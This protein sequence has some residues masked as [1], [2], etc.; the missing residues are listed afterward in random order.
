M[1]RFVAMLAP[2]FLLGALGL[3]AAPQDAQTRL[4]DPYPLETCI[5]SGV[6]LT[7]MGNP[8]VFMHNRR[9]LRF[10]CDACVE[11]FEKGPEKHLAALDKAIIRQQIDS[12]PLT[13]CVVKPE[14][15][16]EIEGAHDVS[17]TLVWNNRLV[18]LCCPGCEEK[19]LADPEKFI[20]VQNDAVIAAQK[21]SYPMNTCVISGGKLGSMGHV[22]DYVFANR[23]VRFCCAPCIEDFEKEPLKYLRQ[24][25]AAAAR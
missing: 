14:D 24:I 6:R 25:D 5:V 9:E 16:L 19:F 15:P 11:T 17:M 4:G 12:Y 2:L 18:R 20:R 13:H 23:L 10:C 7:Q 22:V 8:V 1:K 21:D 3:T